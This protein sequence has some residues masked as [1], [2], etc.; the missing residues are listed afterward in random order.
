[1]VQ[2]LVVKVAQVEM[3]LQIMLVVAVVALELLV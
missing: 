3:E 2:A 1:V